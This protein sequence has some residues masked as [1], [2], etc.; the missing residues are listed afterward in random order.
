VL[1]GDQDR[2]TPP[3]AAVALA[4]ELPD[5]RLEVL[6]GAGHIPMMEA[7]EAF[8]ERLAAFAGPLLDARRKRPRRRAG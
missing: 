8:N 6:E 3:S 2:V 1:V 7:H 5:G 4:D